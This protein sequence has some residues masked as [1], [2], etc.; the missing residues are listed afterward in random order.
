MNT[1]FLII[2]LPSDRPDHFLADNARGGGQYVRGE[3]WKSLPYTHLL[4]GLDL[5]T[6]KTLLHEYP[7]PDWL[8]LAWVKAGGKVRFAPQVK[9]RKTDP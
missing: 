1:P 7:D 3:N 6:S 5:E 2:T 8:M 4:E 9:Q